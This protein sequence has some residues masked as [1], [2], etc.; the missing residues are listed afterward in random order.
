MINGRIGWKRLLYA[1]SVS[2]D[3]LVRTYD[4]RKF[5]Y[6]HPL[7]LQALWLMLFGDYKIIR[8]FL[9]YYRE[10]DYKIQYPQPMIRERIYI[11]SC[12]DWLATLDGLFNVHFF[13]FKSRISL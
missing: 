12:H 11:G 3:E 5:E 1:F 2:Y 10:E 13:F 9:L 4:R 7:R 8:F 6:R